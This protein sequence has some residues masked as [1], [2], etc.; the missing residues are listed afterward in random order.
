M[1]A[2]LS[3]KGMLNFQENKLFSQPASQPASQLRCSQSAYLDP[4]SSP[5]QGVAAPER[6]VE[7][8]LVEQRAWQW[9]GGKVW[10]EMSIN[11]LQVEQV[12]SL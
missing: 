6:H 9:E 7:S 8:Q 10:G 4:C 11:A 12:L 1:E 5:V 2:L 3:L